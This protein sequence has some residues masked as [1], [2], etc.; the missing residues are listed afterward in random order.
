MHIRKDIA[1]AAA[2]AALVGGALA[3]A[4]AAAAAPDTIARPAG[5]GSTYLYTPDG[6][7][8]HVWKTWQGTG[9]GYYKGSW[10][11]Y[12]HSSGVT[13]Y[14]LIDNKWKKGFYGSFTH[15]KNVVLEVCSTKGCSGSW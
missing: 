2:T 15:Q 3:L 8:A 14:A 1:A 5:S 11:T 4:P 7:Y 13:L 10:G 12:T 6:K 9:S